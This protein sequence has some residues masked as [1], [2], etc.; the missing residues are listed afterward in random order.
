[1][2]ICTCRSDGV[3]LFRC[4]SYTHFT[5]YF[6]TLH[7]KVVTARHFGLRHQSKPSNSPSP[8]QNLIPKNCTRANKVK[9]KLG[10]AV[11]VLVS[12]QRRLQCAALQSFLVWGLAGLLLRFS[13][14]ASLPSPR[15]PKSRLGPA[16]CHAAWQSAL[17]Q[18]LIRGQCFTR[19]GLA[20][21]DL[22]GTCEQ[23]AISS[24]KILPN[25]RGRMRSTHSIGN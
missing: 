5:L 21:G 10:N 9:S 13:D 6:V 18:Y 22:I 17:V 24:G 12:R 23:A 8:Q 19:E 25:L 11:L 14:L 7:V 4:L 20:A 2:Y 1:M 15:Q 16:E 3:C